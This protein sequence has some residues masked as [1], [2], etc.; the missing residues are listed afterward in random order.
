MIEE[1]NIVFGFVDVI[2]IVLKIPKNF[3]KLLSIKKSM[4]LIN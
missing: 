1:V 3:K 4:Y 2:D